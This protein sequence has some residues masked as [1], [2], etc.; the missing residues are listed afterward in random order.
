MYFSVHGNHVVFG[1]MNTFSSVNIRF[2][3]NSI[4]NNGS[5]AVCQLSECTTCTNPIM[6]DNTTSILSGDTLYSVERGM[7]V[8]SAVFMDSLTQST[9]YTLVLMLDP[10]ADHSFAYYAASIDFIGGYLQA[11]HVNDNNIIRVT[12]LASNTEIRIVPIQDVYIN[13]SFVYRGEEI[14]FMLNI[15][16]TLTVSSDKDLTGSRVSTNRAI[17]FFSGHYCASGRA[18]NCSILNEQIP[19]YNSWGNTFA[20]HTNISGLRGNMFKIIASDFGANVSINCTTDGTDYEV[21]NYNLGFR[22]HTVLSVSHDYCTVKSDENILI[23]QFRDSS[24][25]LMDTFM[26]IIPALVHYEDSYVLNA[27]E[28]FNNYIAITVKDT[29]PTSNS[30]MI[31]NN[32][33]TVRWQMIELDEN[34]YYFGTLMLTVGKHV[35]EFL[36]NSI[37]FGV[38]QYGSNE[39]DT[40]AL[41]AGMRLNI[42]EILP[43]AGLYIATLSIIHSY[44]LCYYTSLTTYLFSYLAP[45]SVQNASVTLVGNII[46]IT[47]SPP[48]VS[49]GMILQ[50]I[51]QRINSSG[52]SY[53]YVSRNENYLKLPYFHD[54]LIFVA[55][56]N[57]YGQSKYERA[58]SSGKKN[59]I[60]TGSAK[61]LHIII[62]ISMQSLTH[63]I[64][65]K[66]CTFLIV[67]SNS[68]N[69]GNVEAICD[70]I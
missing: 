52:K 9:D 64:S 36:D 17:S 18:T 35:V 54:A 15:K 57:Q 45:S 34:E 4:H 66:S 33:V 31:N 40:F 16:E 7:L 5:I 21:N 39:N 63:F 50:Y 53:Y 14:K 11:L 23:I 44:V 27:H 61:T 25:P 51:V 37:M 58:K 19:P 1:E 59:I 46:N 42:A 20:L 24:P 70:W 30:I 60:V 26:T 68:T 41:Q 12:A 49:N 32:P 3:L 22:Q 67:I 48:S 62:I 6:V 2:L 10:Q 28:G 38:I 43:N 69:I 47:W 65:S 8:A 13:K 56:V 29:D 55:A